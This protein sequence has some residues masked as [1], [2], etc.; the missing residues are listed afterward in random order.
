MSIKYAVGN[1]HRVRGLIYSGQPEAHGPMISQ[2]VFKQDSMGLSNGKGNGRHILF[3]SISAE[4]IDDETYCGSE[5]Y[6]RQKID[7]PNCRIHEDA[8]CKAV[9]FKITCPT[10]IVHFTGDPRYQLN[11]KILAFQYS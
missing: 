10:L 6:C 8:R 2:W 7:D 3:L 5:N 11:G 9:T 4:T 1:P